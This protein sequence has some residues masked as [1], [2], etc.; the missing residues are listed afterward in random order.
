MRPSSPY[1]KTLLCPSR[2]S[3][4]KV[5]LFTCH[6]PFGFSKAI[7]SNS[8]A[9]YSLITGTPNC[10]FMSSLSSSKSISEVTTHAFRVGQISFKTQ[11]FI[12]RNLAN[13]TIELV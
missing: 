10:F 1:G 5:S 2:I 12:R 8:E 3:T 9:P 11:F 7:K 6:F 13:C 4:N